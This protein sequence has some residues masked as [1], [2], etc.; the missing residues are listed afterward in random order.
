M[1]ALTD[2]AFLSLLFPAALLCSLLF[3][4]FFGERG[5]KAVLIV[6]GLFGVYLS[7]GLTAWLPG[8]MIVLTCVLA[9][10]SGK[11]G[12]RAKKIWGGLCCLLFAG[13]RI[14]HVSGTAGFAFLVVEIVICC[15]SGESCL[16]GKRDAF[17]TALCLTFFPAYTSGPV[18]KT[19]TFRFMT[20][21]DALSL[22]E[23]LRR[24]CI[25][26]GK[27]M[28]IAENIYCLTAAGGAAG[29]ALGGMLVFLFSALYVYY[30][31]SGYTDI[32]L[33]MAKCLGFPLPENFNQPFR[34]LSVRDFW[35]RWHI[36]LSSFLRDY[37]Y[38]PLG[39]SRKGNAR[40]VISTLAVFGATVLWHGL[41]LPYL[42]FGLWHALFVILEQRNL[43]K[44]K[45]WPRFLRR[46][47]TLW[48]V[49]TGF[50]FFLCPDASAILRFLSPGCIVGAAAVSVLSPV[51]VLSALMAIGLIFFEEQLFRVRGI[52][53]TLLCA[54]ILLLSLMHR[55]GAGYMPF[56]YGGF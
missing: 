54:L 53:G 2:T 55:A 22:E 15:F 34:A 49:L 23:G 26:M 37:V 6:A 21:P 27:K 28:L 41:T 24:I 40:A 5:A 13:M 32:A 7:D 31:F 44:T 11:T 43:L 46:I 47:Y 18:R 30:D 20:S 51:T 42:L 39:G 19:G 25:G 17:D 8:I 52:K 36:P 9:A 3:R 35:R 4:H 10:V 16:S 38:I 14:L 29:S 12:E 56:L 50:V 45:T 48:V 1:R 33:G